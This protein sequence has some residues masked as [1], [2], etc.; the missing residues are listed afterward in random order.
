MV[1]SACASEVP[2][3]IARTADGSSQVTLLGRIDVGDVWS[4][5]FAVL[6]EPV[7]T[8]TVSDPADPR[9]TLTL[10]DYLLASGYFEPIASDGSAY[11]AISAITLVVK[12]GEIIRIVGNPNRPEV[13]N[14]SIQRG[15]P[16]RPAG[17]NIYK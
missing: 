10:A 12:G 1:L 5:T 4:A 11:P 9:D 7:R 6:G 13:P 17:V 3:S 8:R 15:V 16:G 14:Q 2:A